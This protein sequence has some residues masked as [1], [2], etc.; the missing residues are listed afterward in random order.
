[1]TH[2]QPGGYVMICSLPR[3]AD[4]QAYATTVAHPIA[5]G[6]PDVPGGPPHLV[7][8]MAAEVTVG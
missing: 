4:P 8:G 3:G 6:P 7:L 5:A 2:E 1:M